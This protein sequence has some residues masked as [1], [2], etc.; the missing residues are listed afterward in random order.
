MKVTVLGLN[1]H[2]GIAMVDA[3]A[4]AGHDVTG[5][6]RSNKHPDPRVGF[7][8]GDAEKVEDIRAAIADADV[9]IN[10]LNLRYDLWDNGRL[11]AQAAR[12]VEALGSSG[13]TMMFAGS[14]YNYPAADG[15]ITPDAEQRPAMRRGVL[16]ATVEGLFEA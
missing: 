9:V 6:G 2:L 3:F 10:A 4:S 8:K 15:V 1:G 7:F 12:V 16:R 5:F 11:E 13:K 14:I